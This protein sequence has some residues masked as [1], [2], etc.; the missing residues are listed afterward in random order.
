MIDCCKAGVL[1]FDMDY[2]EQSS[3]KVL[4]EKINRRIGQAFHD[5]SMLSDGDQVLVAVSGG[6]DSLVLAW[7]LKMWQAKAPI[8]YFLKAITIDNGFWTPEHV[9]KSPSEIIGH[10]LERLGIPLVVEKARDS[11]ENRERTCF[12]CARSRRTQLFE[13]ARNHGFNKIA[14]GHHKDDLVETLFLNMLYSGN[15]STMVPRQELFGGELNLI[16]PLAYIEK[17]D[18]WKIA[19]RLCIEPIDNLCPLANDTRREQ[20]R[21]IL[22][23]IYRKEPGAK[24]SIFAAMSNIR[25]GYMP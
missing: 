19:R 9:G 17:D 6:V 11:F 12:L 8:H 20:V 3:L 13:Y 22:E 4:P 10:E 21:E 24:A 18:I 16:R 23:E 1:F 2:F 25:E 5:Y 14:L 15:I 7:L